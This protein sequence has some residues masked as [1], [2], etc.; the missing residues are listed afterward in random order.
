MTRGVRLLM[1]TLTIH[2]ATSFLAAQEPAEDL[3]DNGV[4]TT[5]DAVRRTVRY[6]YRLI[7]R[8]D[9]PATEID[10]Y[11]P[12]PR[13]TPRQI[14]HYV[15]L[16]QR[17]E[18]QRIFTDHH[19]QRLVHYRLD[20]LEPGVY[21]DLGYVVGVTLKNLRWNPAESTPRK[22]AP[23]LTAEERERYLQ[24]ETN[25]SMDSAMMRSVSASLVEGA[26]SDYEK[27]VRIHDHV[28]SSIRY[29][30][31]DAWDPAETVL[32]RGTGSCSEYNYVLSGLCRLAGLPTRCVGGSSNGHRELPTTDTVY[33]R[34]TE[35]FLDG[36]GWFPADCSRDGNPIRGKRSHFGRIYVDALVWCQQAGG[37]EDTL[38]WDYRAKAHIR[39]EKSRVR[40]SHRTRWF[41]FQPEGKVEAARAWFLDGTGEQPDPDLLEC[42]LVHWHEAPPENQTKMLRALAVAGRNACLRRAGTL[43]QTD[44]RRTRAVRDLCATSE[45]AETILKES[46][47]LAEFR[48]WFRDNESRLVPAGEGKFQRAA[49]G[50]K[51]KTGT[52][53]DSAAEI[54]AS[55]VPDVASRFKASLGPEEKPAIVVMPIT[56]QT[57]A[58]LG[59]ES[60]SIHEALKTQIAK[61]LADKV[62]D[63]VQFDRW[64]K[65]DGPGSGEYWILANGEVGNVPAE[66]AADIVVV[67]VCITSRS[68]ESV[69]YHLELK[70]LDLRHS[71]YTKAVARVYRKTADEEVPG[72]ATLVGGGD[73]VLARWE[74]DMVSRQSYAW[75]LDG[76]ES[77]LGS[78]DAALCNL[79]CCVSRRGTPA[80]KGEH[81]PFFYRARPEM[82]QCLTSAGIDVVTGANNHGGDYGPASVADTVG[83]CNTAGLVCVG[84]GSNMAEA[85]TPHVVQIGPLRVAF[86]GMDSTKAC[87]VAGNDRPGAS[88][89]SEE[90][91]LADFTAKVDRIARWADGRCDLLVLTIHWGQ[92]W[93]RETQPVHRKM[94]RIALEHG[95]DAILGHSAHRLQ[96]IEL[97]DGKPVVYDMGNL[98]FDCKLKP[99]GR[100]SALF[101]LQ[102][103][104]NGV[105]KIEVLPVE[106][107]NGH[108]ARAGCEE[109]AE[110]L[111]EMGELCSALGTNLAIEEDLEGRPMG[112]VHI[113]K[114]KSTPRKAVDA[115]QTCVTLPAKGETIPPAL[116][117]AFLNREIPADAKKL[118]PPVELASGVELVACRVPAQAEEGGIL[119]LTT[120]W[121]VA[122]PVKRDVMLAFHLRPKGETPRRGTPWYTRHDGADWTVPLS[123]VDPAAVI[124][125]LYPARL[126][127]LPAG[128]CEVFAV[129]IDTSRSEGERVLGETNLGPI[130]IV[131]RAKRD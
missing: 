94:A 100:Q 55:L 5:W 68:K 31:D 90:G 54:W 75:P 71:K 15:E 78:A 63:E 95:V 32:T 6:D 57:L 80:E 113:A 37:E 97:I 79:E 112:V 11:V 42:A 61:T 131:P 87:Y 81:C 30:R 108:T 98:L 38:G 59:A 104:K 48:D 70:T 84:I 93:V 7:N 77:V 56:D 19:G 109:A 36:F 25:Y 34:W 3:R 85:E 23:T 2:L 103:S 45:L 82:L 58:G 41:D 111:S 88:Y 117:T 83:W 116:D 92:N 8:S 120:W 14:I 101:R 96:G 72:S 69:L 62:V 60:P 46:Q 99:E 110:I 13:K 107:L 126:S 66:V 29:V 115:T 26:T 1:L 127:G 106:A 12:L 89:A 74:H 114:P 10:V 76:V 121:R 27:L 73:T 21:V 39:G 43:P 52:T 18:Q 128:P 119:Q 35:V 129:L 105:H 40:E 9:K 49:K 28:A 47:N 22:N 91:N 65:T 50:A 4:C 64:M 53:T 44:E 24:A 17:P 123:L 86:A 33:H 122:E 124:E 130:E 16:P 102:L 51:T 125:D 118:A 67:P 20:R